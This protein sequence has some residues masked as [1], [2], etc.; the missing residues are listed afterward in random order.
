MSDTTARKTTD[1]ACDWMSAVREY[2]G[3][4]AVRTR[5]RD[6]LGSDASGAI[7][8]VYIAANDAFGP[9]RPVPLAV[10]ALDRCLDEG[11]EIYRSLWDRESLVVDLD[12]EYVNFD[13]PHDPYCHIEHAFI[14]QQPVLDGARMVFAQCGL[15]PLH[16][17]SGRGHHLVWRISK[18]SSA[19]LQLG[20]LGRVPSSLQAKYDQP[21]APGGDRISPLLGKAFAGLGCVLEFLA[22]ET[23]RVAVPRTQVPV[24]LT[25]VEASSERGVREGVSLDLSEYADPLHMRAVRVPFSVYYKPVQ[26]EMPSHHDVAGQLRPMILVP[27]EPRG[28]HRTLLVPNNV[29]AAQRLARRAVSRIPE[30]STGMSRLIARYRWSPLARI[31]DWFYAQDHD[32]PPTWAR[33]YDLTAL[34]ALP[35]SAQQILQEP[36]D[37]LLKPASL[38][39]L[40]RLFLALGWHPRHIAGLVR[41]KLERDYGWGYEWFHYDAASRADS[42]CRIFTGLLLA[43]L[44]PIDGWRCPP[45]GPLQEAAQRNDE[46]YEPYERS[47]KQ[48]IAYDR[49]ASRPFHRLF[50]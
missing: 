37:L 40:V 50:L 10:E 49:L 43:G 1:Q 44:D 12:I 17:L 32:D 4:A 20:Q 23:L 28:E 31:H 5:I 19:F 30:Q 2:Y 7:A 41:S 48:R 15:V 27:A 45:V 42:Y 18:H 26:L 39:H 3:N 38:R 21:L 14:Q 36:N 35:H 46:D 9:Q 33:T 16:V 34:E 11:K 25:A 24:S 13:M 8:A 22:H 47:L 6:F 29:T